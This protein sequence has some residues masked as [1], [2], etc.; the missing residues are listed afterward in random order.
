MDPRNFLNDTDIFQFLDLGNY[1]SSGATLS[2]I[3]YQVNDTFLKNYASDIMNACK[4]KNI[5][6]HNMYYIYN[7][8]AYY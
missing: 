3:K 8:D 4:S 2:S 7:M 1:Q 6:S 5:N